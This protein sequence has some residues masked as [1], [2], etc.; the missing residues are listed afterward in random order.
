MMKAGILLDA[1][2]I[3]HAQDVNGKTPIHLLT[4]KHRTQKRFKMVGKFAEYNADFNVR[5]KGGLTPLDEAMI[6]FDS[7]N[8]KGALSFINEMIRHG[9][10]NG[11][12]K[13]NMDHID[14]SARMKIMR[15]HH[16]WKDVNNE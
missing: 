1:G 14:A 8:I 7:R 5:D 12:S 3:P 10:R 13:L 4:N 6:N 11:N 2:A 15:M 9:A 16:K